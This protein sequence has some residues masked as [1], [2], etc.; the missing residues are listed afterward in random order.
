MYKKKVVYII[1]ATICLAVISACA[2]LLFKYSPSNDNY[3]DLTLSCNQLS[4]GISSRLRFDDNFFKYKNDTHCVPSIECAELEIQ[5]NAVVCDKV[6][7]FKISFKT[8]NSKATLILNIKR[9]ATIDYVSFKKHEITLYSNS[10]SQCK[11]LLMNKSSLN[12]FDKG[13]SVSSNEN[14]CSLNM[15]NMEFITHDIGSTRLKVE[16]TSSLGFSAFDYIDINVIAKPPVKIIL[17]DYYNQQHITSTIGALQKVHYTVLL[18]D[19]LAY[20]QTVS[21]TILANDTDVTESI[22]FAID[23]ANNISFEFSI[24]GEYKFIAVANEDESISVQ[25]YYTIN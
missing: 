10:S 9:S 8:E 20:N 19:E 25:L 5:D 24:S 4:V 21:I 17:D 2:I 18:G 23:R 11:L 7:T 15:D 1:L 12:V 22:H 13:F 3:G 16:L 6:G 14:I